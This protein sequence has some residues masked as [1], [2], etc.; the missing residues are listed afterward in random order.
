[1]RWFLMVCVFCLSTVMAMA[2]LTVAPTP[3]PV[4]LS[5]GFSN[6]VIDHNGRVLVF[7]A[8][9]SYPPILDVQPVAVRFTPTVTTHVTVI[10]SNAS[11]NKDAR[12]DGMFQ[13]VGV[14]RYAVYAI[15]TNYTVAGNSFQGAASTTRQLVALG[16]SFPTLPSVDIPLGDTVKVSAVGD[17]GAPDE[18]AV[19]PNV[20]RPLMAGSSAGSAGS[21][22]TIA[23]VHPLP[24]TPPQQRTVQMYTFDGKSTSFT[25]LPPVT[26]SNP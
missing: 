7:D 25:A 6:S 26:L 10:E 4:P 1:M 2:Q 16:A 22:G 12:Y 18:I 14:G 8:I 5:Y 24:P 13:V 19:V 15:I 21:A 17:D 3:V 20:V 9:Y 11:S 23:I